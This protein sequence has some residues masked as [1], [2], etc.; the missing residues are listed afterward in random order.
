VRFQ[1]LFT[2]SVAILAIVSCA[3]A[4]AQTTSQF[5]P[6]ADVRP[7]MK[8][9]VRTVLEGNKIQEFQVELIG[10]VKNF[11]APKHDAIL[12][13]L[14]GPS[15]QKVG[16]AG[17]MSGSPV[18]VYGKL[19]GALAYGIPF[20][21]EPYTL[22]T[23]IQDVLGVVPANSTRS[24][25]QVALTLP[26]YSTQTASLNGTL[27]RWIPAAD[28]GPKAWRAMV[29][30]WT[31]SGPMGQFRLPLD[32]SGFDPRVVSEYRPVFEAMGFQPEEA[33]VLSSEDSSAD[34]ASPAVMSQ[35]MPGSMI[36]LQLVRGDLNLEAGC[37]VTYRQG[38]NIYA[39]GHPILLMGPSQVPFAAAHVLATIP[40]LSESQKFDASGPVVGSIHQD[41]FGAIYGVLGDRSPVIPIHLHVVSSLDRTLDYNF[42]VAQQPLLS[43]IL[44]NMALV[45]AISATE[46]MEG[47][48]TLDLNGNIELGDG[49]AVRL[50]NV[51]SSNLSSAGAAGAAV[52]TPLSYLLDG[53]FPHLRIKA[54]NLNVVS[55]DES[56]IATL[57]QVWSTKSEVRPGDN[58][59]VTAVERMPSGEQLT[60][61]I[62]VDIPQNVNDKSLSL[63]VGSGSAINALELRFIRPGNP[64]NALRQLVRELNRTRRNNRV[65]ALLMAPQRSFVMEGTDFPS[66][67]P[68]LLRTFLADPAVS[69]KIVYRAGSLVGDFNTKSLPYTID[70]EETLYL[71][72]LSA[73]K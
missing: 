33:A 52:A 28:S 56:R 49:E 4:W 24:R 47:P 14:S 27:D 22:I 53:Q 48:S 40:I 10:V 45:S 1:R 6:L 64:P 32:F 73:T 25:P 31:Q 69:S 51:I 71:K 13:R 72:V 15:I 3:S 66:P 18:Y 19:L 65:Y 70:G 26:W 41:R 9:V 63:V 16:V 50:E 60:Q 12:A 59:V 43:P 68:S 36:S 34:A 38:N 39:C 20:A 17:G 21:K 2:V 23:P 58:I 7:G 54:I 55:K 46:R 30:R 8:G 62:P 5:F 11:G 67:P 29:D 57:E 61:T 44:V 37:T 42:E 35:V